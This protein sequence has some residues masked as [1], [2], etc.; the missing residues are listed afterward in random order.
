MRMCA[1]SDVPS[2]TCFQ[3]I[4]TKNQINFQNVDAE[5]GISQQQQQQ[6]QTQQQP[7]MAPSILLD[8]LPLQTEIEQIAN[9][10]PIQAKDLN[11]ADLAMANDFIKH[12]Q[13]AKNEMQN[14]VVH[15][16]NDRVRI[17]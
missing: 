12:M 8:N 16:P 14:A 3:Y 2:G 13:Q 10:M 6:A 15:P 11:A 17:F 7:Q 1:M 4:Q 9:R 5:N